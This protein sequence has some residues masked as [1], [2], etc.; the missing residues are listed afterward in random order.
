MDKFDI[1]EAEA[2]AINAIRDKLV[3]RHKVA[4]IILE[5]IQGEGGDNHFRPEFFNL[6][7]R[8]ADENEVLLI[9]DERTDRAGTY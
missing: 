7:R 6:L 2:E 5:T 3:G 9:L 8:V 1:E 4:A